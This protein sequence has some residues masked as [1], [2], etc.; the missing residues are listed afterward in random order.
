MWLH[1]I[2]YSAGRMSTTAA[3]SALSGHLTN[4]YTCLRHFLE[5]SCV[6]A[7][8]GQDQETTQV[9]INGREQMNE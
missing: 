8:H 7:S 1:S 9:P 5:R 3:T 4:V 6:T 2:S